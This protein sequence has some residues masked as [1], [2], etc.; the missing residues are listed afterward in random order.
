MVTKEQPISDALRRAVRAS[1]LTYSAIE[2]AT[3]VKRASVMRFMRGTQSLRLDM[4]DR[5]AAYLGLAMGPAK[6]RRGQQARGGK[7]GP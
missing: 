1:G 6:G 2:R 7:S 4:A 3:G 5:L